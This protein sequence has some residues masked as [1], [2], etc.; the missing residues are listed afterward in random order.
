MG[1][2]LQSYLEHHPEIENMLS[3][4]AKREFRVSRANYRAKQVAEILF[5]NIEIEQAA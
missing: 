1:K 5:Q 2:K 4:S 3:K